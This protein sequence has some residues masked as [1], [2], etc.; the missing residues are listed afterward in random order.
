MCPCLHLIKANSVKII[1]RRIFNRQKVEINMVKKMRSL[2]KI[3]LTNLLNK[4]L[5]QAHHCALIDP[6]RWKSKINAGDF[7]AI[8]AYGESKLAQV[9]H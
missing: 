3:Q 9:S 1:F 4:L 2:K 5:T 8:R 7:N 6:T